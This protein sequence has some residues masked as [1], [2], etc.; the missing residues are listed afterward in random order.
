MYFCKFA[1]QQQLQDKSNN[2]NQAFY[3]SYIPDFLKAFLEE[4]NLAFDGVFSSRK[5]PNSVVRHVVCVCVGTILPPKK[6]QHP[7]VQHTHTFSN[8]DTTRQNRGYLTRLCFFI[9]SYHIPCAENE[10]QSIS[11]DLI[12]SRLLLTCSFHTYQQ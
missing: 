9:A 12:L 1:T 8:T 4:C 6:F 3:Y 11:A 2:W 5:Q 10:H 7:F